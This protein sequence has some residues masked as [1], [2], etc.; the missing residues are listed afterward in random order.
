MIED[1][2]GKI[3]NDNINHSTVLTSAY[4]GTGEITDTKY[5]DESEKELAKYNEGTTLSKDDTGKYIVTMT[6]ANNI[7]A[8]N[9][10][11]GTLGRV[12]SLIHS[13]EIDSGAGNDLFITAADTGLPVDRELT[14]N[15]GSGNDVYINGISNR[16]H[17]IVYGT[18]GIFRIESSGYALQNG[19][20]QIYRDGDHYQRYNTEGG[21]IN[22]AIINMGDGDDTLLNVGYL[23]T[24]V[25]IKGSKIDMG[26]G[27]DIITLYGDITDAWN[28]I[29]G[30][31]G[32]DSF[33]HNW[34]AVDSKYISGFETLNL[35]NKS[36]LKLYADYLTKDGGIE[37]GILKIN[38][39][40]GTSVDLGNNGNNLSDNNGTWTKGEA[41]SEDGVNYH[42]YTHSG[43]PD[44]QV[45]I[46]D[47]IKQVI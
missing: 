41:K 22:N 44:V 5:W 45:W 6:D 38:G 3:I 4:G 7:I 19:E 43:N 15:T 10:S 23:R 17:K 46:D 11:I 21:V 37:E 47:D 27:S 34:G 2:K 24:N 30:G 28:S 13:F 33:T 1:A 26:A 9:E 12:N 31:A 36:A 42:V 35:G 39:E 18:D 8:T 16:E 14:I 40:S 29:K 20:H 32:I 25:S